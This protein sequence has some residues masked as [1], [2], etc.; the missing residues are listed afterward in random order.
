MIRFYAPN[1]PFGEFSNFSRDRVN[2]YERDWQ[3]SEHPFQAMKFWPHRPDLVQRV[4][5]A[6]S[7]GKAALLGRNRAY[8]LRPDWDSM[9]GPDLVDRAPPPLEVDDG[10]NRA[11]GPTEP[12]F[13]RAKDVFMWEIVLTKFYHPDLMKLLVGTGDEPIV[14]DAMDDPYWGWGASKVGQNKLGRILMEVRE[15]LRRES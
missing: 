5:E 10:V 11:G 13:V 8:P 4:W 14:E 12:L 15:V 1:D 6:K 2:I 9:P 3:T 7:P